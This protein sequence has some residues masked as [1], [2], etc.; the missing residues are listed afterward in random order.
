MLR[1]IAEEFHVKQQEAQKTGASKDLRLLR[2][3]LIASELLRRGISFDKLSI[4]SQTR[5][6]W[7]RL[8]SKQGEPPTWQQVVKALKESDASLSPRQEQRVR[9]ILVSLSTQNPKV[10]SADL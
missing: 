8:E 4:E 3:I 9:A 1:E 2:R 6:V 5:Y 7:Y 10:K